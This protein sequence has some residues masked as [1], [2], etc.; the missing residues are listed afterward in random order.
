MRQMYKE[1]LYKEIRLCVHPTSLL[2]FALSA[3]LLIPNY[4]YYVVFFYS[5]LGVF[6]MCL[7]G[8]ENHDIFYSLLL[9]VEK[10]DLVKARIGAVALIEIV[11]ILLAIPFMFL[12]STF[13]VPGNLVG[14]DANWALLGLGFIMLGGFNIV[15]FGRYYKKPE[16][17]GG[18]FAWG[19]VWITLYML[20]AEASA[21]ICPFVMNVL[22]GP[23][24]SFFAVKF[25]VF[26]GGFTVFV[27]LSLFA[28]KRG[29]RS[30]EKLD[31]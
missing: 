22:D 30:F 31:L 11:Q 27:L 8:R 21:H 3:M 26:V 4:P 2:F 10:K 28:Y 15:F 1:L 13:P 17:V 19:S 12:R 14:M 5:C 25:A 7:Q 18:A 16:S 24:S 23:N 9:P 29:S 6:F 20:V